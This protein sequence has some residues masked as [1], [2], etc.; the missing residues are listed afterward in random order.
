M[1][2]RTV[3]THSLKGTIYLNVRQYTTVLVTEIVMK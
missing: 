2:N 1:D 3:K